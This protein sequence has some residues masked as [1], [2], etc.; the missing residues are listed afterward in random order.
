MNNKTPAEIL[1]LAFPGVKIK[2]KH[3][4]ALTEVVARC[5][6]CGRG[7]VWMAD[8]LETVKC[9]DSRCPKWHRA[10]SKQM[11]RYKQQFDGDI[12]RPRMKGYR[13]R[14]CDCG[15][16]HIVDFFIRDKRVEY[17]VWRDDR[18]TANAR[19][20]TL[21]HEPDL[22]T[23]GD[24]WREVRDARAEYEEMKEERGR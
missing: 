20:R 23:S 21:R 14:C 1:A 16:V 24:N 13:V 8:G 18:A 4:T 7:Y 17:Q 6:A 3:P 22:D 11:S 2:R 19:K 10:P 9:M 5:D 15:L 12:V